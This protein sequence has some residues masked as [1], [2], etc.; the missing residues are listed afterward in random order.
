MTQ[1]ED[2]EELNEDE[3]KILMWCDEK[4]VEPTPVNVI[5]AMYA[6]HY[7]DWIGGDEIA[8]MCEPCSEPNLQGDT[9]S[10]DNMKS[11]LIWRLKQLLPLTYWTKY[12]MGDQPRFTIWRMWF[13]HCFD[14]VDIPV[15]SSEPQSG[16]QISRSLWSEL[17]RGGPVAGT[18]SSAT[19]HIPRHR[20]VAKSG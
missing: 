8:P 5:Q 17:R 11:K 12:Q 14:V 18:A 20:T 1:Q 15:Q 2:R 4:K 3:Q 9:M 19:G 6:L 10:K 16:R 13:G 7:A